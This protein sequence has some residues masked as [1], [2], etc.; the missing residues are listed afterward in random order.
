MADS[1]IYTLPE[2]SAPSATDFAVVDTYVESM[3]G[4]ITNKVTI[5]TI[6]NTI[7]A[8]IVQPLTS[9]LP[10]ESWNTV[11]ATT[12]SFSADWNSTVTTVSINSANWD[13][14]YESIVNNSGRWNDVSDV[15]ESS[16]NR[17]SSTSDTVDVGAPIWNN[18]STAVVSNSSQWNGGGEAST[19]LEINSGNWQATYEI[20]S[21]LSSTWLSGGALAE[22]FDGVQTEVMSAS[23]YGEFMK[24]TIA[25]QPRAIRLWEY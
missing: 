22:V 13:A 21:S 2:T 6:A 19:T 1:Y 23:F 11:Y 4:F 10:I 8:S 25:G 5:N 15:V 20:V 16:S 14:A 3:S 9:W 18:T 17:W 12:T 7:S 24:V